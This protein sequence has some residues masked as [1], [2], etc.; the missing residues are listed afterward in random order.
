MTQFVL[1]DQLHTEAVRE[2]ISHWST[3]RFLRDLRPG[4]VIKDERVPS[5]L[6]ALR[7]ATFITI[8]DGF[9]H[10][11]LRDHRYCI[12]YFA[13]RTDEQATIPVLLRRLLRL[14]ASRTRAARMGKVVRVSRGRIT[15]WQLG[16]D[17]QHTSAWSVPPRHGVST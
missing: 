6:R 2:P 7:R 10:R 1:D 13:L 17:R 12:V 14:P 5:I 8:D 9:W 11:N 16:D 4:E 3:A 15:W